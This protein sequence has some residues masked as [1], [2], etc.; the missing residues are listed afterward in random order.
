[1][2]ALPFIAGDITKAVLAAAVA[3]GVTPKVAYNGETDREK[4]TRWRLP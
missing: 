2:G 4:W 1:M 3:R